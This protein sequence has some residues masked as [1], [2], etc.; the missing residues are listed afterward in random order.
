MS[1]PVFSGNTH[2]Y[3]FVNFDNKQSFI[4]EKETATQNNLFPNVNQKKQY[5]SPKIVNYVANI[6]KD[7][8]EIN[9]S[10]P[11]KNKNI[12]KTFLAHLSNRQQR[13]IKEVSCEQGIHSYNDMLFL[14]SKYIEDFFFPRDYINLLNKV[15]LKDNKENSPTI[16]RIYQ[17]IA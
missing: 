8:Y 9:D 11:E 17:Y 6:T 7:L 1:F 3:K 12:I 5:H 4:Y 13:H 14:F 10:K 15:S 16:N 2:G